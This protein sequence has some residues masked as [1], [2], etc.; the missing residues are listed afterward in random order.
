[1]VYHFV[2]DLRKMINVFL[3]LSLTDLLQK[4]LFDEQCMYCMDQTAYALELNHLDT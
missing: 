4:R 3:P 1:M 2:I